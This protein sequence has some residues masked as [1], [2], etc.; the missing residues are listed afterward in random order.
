MLYALWASG[1]G[2]LTLPVL[3][4]RAG[5]RLHPAEWARLCVVAVAGGA[6]VV[7]L[8][9]VLY[10]L[11]TLATASRIPTLAMLCQR[12]LGPL[13]PGGN[14]AGWTAAAVAV[15]L[16]VLGCL[17]FARSQR[18]ARAA[19]IERW[20]GRHETYG[21]DELVV[22]PTDRVIAVSVPAV[23]GLAARH[24]IVVSNGLVDALTG[25]QLDAVLLH[26]AAHLR[27][28]H[29]RYLAVAAVVDHAFAWF[30][31]VRASTAA[32]RLA[33][34]RSAD[35]D[36]AVTCGDRRVVREALVA[37]TASLIA[38]PALAAFSAAETIGERLQALAEEPLHPRLAPHVLLYCPGTML[39][40][41]ALVTV[42]WWATGASAVLSMAGT[43]FS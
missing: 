11:P 20:L 32:L 22:L 30:L 37:V 18:G 31:P 34:E 7:E 33:L 5:R 3:A 23:P 15:V 29:Y 41:V 26:E 9:A 8:A 40:T 35:E 21:Q 36:A 13:A 43:C 2:L 12:M 38:G 17:G 28:G 4:R 25:E 1:F 19:R 24:Q 14:V 27:R 42:W 10:A 16:P 6:A 39:G